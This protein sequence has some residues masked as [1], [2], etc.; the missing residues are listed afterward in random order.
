MKL[1]NVYFL[2][3]L[4]F[5]NIF[6]TL[7]ADDQLDGQIDA[8]EQAQRLFKERFTKA[9]EIKNKAQILGYI[10]QDPSLMLL[11]AES[12]DF[13]DNSDETIRMFTTM[14]KAGV[15]LNYQN[16]DGESILHITVEAFFMQTVMR[17]FF[18][19]IGN[20]ISK[21]FVGEEDEQNQESS[22]LSESEFIL[23]IQNTQKIV[24]AL[25]KLGVNK[26]LK[27]RESRQTAADYVKEFIDEIKNE[28]DKHTKIMKKLQKLYKTLK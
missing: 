5:F 9:V 22:F 27:T 6:Y 2:L 21:F 7:I 14:K 11:F 17:E 25:Y 8:Q 10:K 12:D 4:S 28:F 13:L 19:K 26:H 1:K 3:F 18:N 23:K 20:A 24:Q 16:K 15:N